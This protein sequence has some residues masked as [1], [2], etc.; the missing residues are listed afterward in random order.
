MDQ[1]AQY[2]I[3]QYATLIGNE[4]VS[5]WCPIAWE[6]FCDY[7]LNSTHLSNQE[8]I[9]IR[10]CISGSADA[11]RE[12]LI[13]NQLLFLSDDAWKKSRELNEIEMKLR[14]FGIEPTWE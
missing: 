7:R 3:R 13:A 1:H 12:Y 10:L 6:A 9:L 4:I 14:M 5:K 11:A 2:E 8:T